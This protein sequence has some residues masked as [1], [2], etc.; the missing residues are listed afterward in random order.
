[1]ELLKVSVSSDEDRQ[2]V[3][4]LF[5]WLGL[6]NAGVSNDS[7]WIACDDEAFA[8]YSNKEMNSFTIHKFKEVTLSQ[9]RDIVVL[10]RNDV[11]DATHI[12]YDNDA[13]YF[14]GSSGE[15][16]YF[17]HEGWHKIKEPALGAKP[18]EKEM[19]EYLVKVGDNYEYRMKPKDE[20]PCEGWIEIPK[21]AEMLCEFYS[22]PENYFA[23]YKNSSGVLCCYAGENRWGSTG[24]DSL[25]LFLTERKESMCVVWQRKKSLNDQCVEIEEVRQK[26]NAID[27]TLLERQTTYGCYEDVAQTTQEILKALRIG[28]YDNMPAPHK[29]SLHMIASKMARIVNGDF[30][31]KDGWHDIGGYAKLIE[32]L[33]GGE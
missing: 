28:Q 5:S 1:M 27:D 18:I 6:N 31:H 33:I 21:G 3:S 23:F 24:W 26:H 4:S 25:D 32:N 17:S 15:W 9:L 20:E 14:L 13:K 29:E 22:E 7:E 19:K 30:N 8:G 2:E 11:N 12:A 10:K 16:Y